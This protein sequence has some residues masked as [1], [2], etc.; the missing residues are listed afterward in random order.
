[1]KKQ[2]VIASVYFI[3]YIE[4]LEKALKEGWYIVPGT[5]VMTADKFIAIVEVEGN[6]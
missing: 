1:M 5:I 4:E 3:K 2:K 6:Y